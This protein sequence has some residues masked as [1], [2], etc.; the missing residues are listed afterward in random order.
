MHFN[1]VFLEERFVTLRGRYIHYNTGVIR[2]LRAFKPDVVVTGGFNPTHLYAFGYALAHRLPHVAMT[3]GTFHSELSLSWMHRLVRR[4]VYARSRAFVAAS[5]GGR[6]LYASYGVPAERCFQSCLCVDNDAFR[7]AEAPPEKRFDFLFCGRIEEVK[8]PLFALEVACKTAQRVGRKMHM[9]YVGA[10]GQEDAVREAATAWSQ[11]VAV[12]FCGFAE[13]HALPSLY[14]AARIFLFPSQWDP[15]GVVA[16]EACAAGLPVL[17]SPHA[18]VANELVRD[19][20]N[21]FV[22]RL[23]SELWAE[24]AAS[25]IEQPAV[26]HRFS[27]RAMQRVSD[28]TY[29]RAAAGV[30]DACRYAM[31]HPGSAGRL[32]RARSPV[33]SV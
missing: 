26:W 11:H 2:A 32:T 6:Q 9:L 28:Y 3:D 13:H 5:N 16:N 24:R 1:H 10:G 27:E 18:G 30:R 17:V 14:Q 20:E 25:L 7:P 21:G 15:W 22:C 19:G 29:D 31:H 8:N 4:F 33:R 23:D 12:T